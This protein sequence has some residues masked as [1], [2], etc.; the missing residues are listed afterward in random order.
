MSTFKIRSDGLFD[1][2]GKYPNPLTNQPYSKIYTKISLDKEPKGWALLDAYTDRIKILQKIH[3]NKI[4]IVSLPTGV[5]KTVIIPK[6]LLHYF[7]YEKKII[8][9]TP[10]QET[11]ASAGIFASNCLDVPLFHLEDKDGKISPIIDKKN[12]TNEYG[13]KF[14]TGYKIVGYKH[15]DEKKYF[16]K[17]TKLLFTT[18]GSVKGM[19]TGGDPYLEE[20]GGIIIDEVHERSLDIDT[21]ISLVMNILKKRPDFKIIFMSATMDTSIFEDYFKKLGYGYDYSIYTLPDAE[22]TYPI[23]YKLESKKKSGINV[24]TLIDMA[25]NKVLEIMKNIE[26]SKNPDDKI[27]NILIFLASE[28][29]IKTLINKINKNISIF[30]DDNKPMVYKLS[31]NTDKKDTDNATGDAIPKGYARKIIIATPMAESSITFKGKLKYIID[32]GIAYTTS[33][34]AKR[35]CF[36]NGKNYTTQ[37]NIKQRCGRTGRTCEGECIQLY[38]KDQF[39]NFNKFTSPKILEEDFT[40]NLLN[41]LK[42]KENETNIIKTLKFVK[43]MIEPFDKFKDYVKVAYNNLKEMDF[44]EPNGDLSTLGKICSDDFDKFDI[45][46]AKM[47]ICGYFFNCAEYTIMLGAILHIVSNFSD[48]II[49]L[50]NEDLKDK[51]KVEHYNKTINNLIYSESDHITLLKI[52][53]NYLYSTDPLAFTKNNYLNNKKLLE[54]KDAYINLRELIMKKNS[55]TKKYKIEEFSKLQQFKNIGKFT[56]N[57]GFKLNNKNLLYNKNETRTNNKTT[58]YN[59]KTKYNLFTKTNNYVGG[60]YTKSTNSR[61]TF[62]NKRR[63]NFFKQINT[64]RNSNYLNNKIMTTNKYKKTLKTIKGGNTNN[65][66]NKMRKKYMELFTLNQFKLRNK[67]APTTPP[68]TPKDIIDRVIACL[69]YG[70]STNIACNSGLNKEYFVKFSNVKGK[71]LGNDTKSSF[72]YKPPKDIPDYVIYNTFVITKNFG[73][74]KAIGSLNL[75]TKLD[76]KHLNYF[77]D[78]QELK[79]KV[80]V[81]IK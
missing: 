18:D 68:K 40:K 56:M 63:Q 47:I 69:Y 64:K 43:N 35:Y 76:T 27:G 4:L 32:S 73:K 41:L 77:F 81:S 48:I 10:R 30:T 49:T 62:K 50:S 52:F 39:N 72:D 21:V 20:Y 45:R 44:I 38:T 29:D 54:I 79:N 60:F 65:N 3:N 66:L 5:G 78:L 2:E 55:K 26:N 71:L 34:D 31:S 22:T 53:N 6:L 19:I 36:I 33:F 42:L 58:F 8:V 25:Y 37:A 61:N 80:I 70:Y 7:G 75:V 57:G 24:S 13:G 1:P 46:I 16:N 23:E 74:E 17:T 11:T 15:G 28:N 67:S 14:P 12:E 51:L 9:T 59:S